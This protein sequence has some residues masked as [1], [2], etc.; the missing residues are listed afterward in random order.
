MENIQKLYLNAIQLLHLPNGIHNL[1]YDKHK[2][3]CKIVL[4]TLQ[5]FQHD[6]PTKSKE[7]SIIF[8]HKKTRIMTTAE[9]QKTIKAA[10]NPT[11][12]KHYKAKI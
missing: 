6:K 7:T 2:M 3:S 4:Q 10:Q 9:R 1:L 11:H 8:S 5:L 12:L